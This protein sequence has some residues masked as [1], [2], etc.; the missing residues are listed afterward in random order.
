LEAAADVAHRHAGSC[1]GSVLEG[2]FEWPSTTSPRKSS[3][4]ETFYEL[5]ESLHRVTENPAAKGKTRVLAIIRTRGTR[6]R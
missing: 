4:C 3:T 5:T 6:S 2:E 1:D